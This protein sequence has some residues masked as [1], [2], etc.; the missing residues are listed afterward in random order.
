MALLEYDRPDPDIIRPDSSVELL[1][2]IR[3][4]WDIGE[5]YWDMDMNNAMDHLT[6]WI[7]PVADRWRTPYLPLPGST[8]SGYTMIMGGNAGAISHHLRRVGSGDSL[9]WWPITGGCVW[10]GN[11]ELYVTFT[12]EEWKAVASVPR[13]LPQIEIAFF[14][15][16][17]EID[18]VFGKH[19]V[20]EPFVIPRNAPGSRVRNVSYQSPVRLFKNGDQ[21]GTASVSANGTSTFICDETE[22]EVG[23]ELTVRS[24]NSRRV[25]TPTLS[26]LGRVT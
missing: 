6:R 2:P 15:D 5:H 17:P 24:H 18:Q 19:I 1:H 25:R 16:M 4:F 13:W 9:E 3:A 7:A 20:V 12:G 10:I 14:M 23:D 11:E 22:F 26:I 8:L 21:I